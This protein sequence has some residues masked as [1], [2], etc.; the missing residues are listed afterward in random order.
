MGEDL[1]RDGTFLDLG[2]DACWNKRI[3]GLVATGNE[4]PAAG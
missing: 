1:P 2:D 3:G 4:D